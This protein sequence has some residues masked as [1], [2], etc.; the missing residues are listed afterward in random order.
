[1]NL[2]LFAKTRVWHSDYQSIILFIIIVGLCHKCTGTIRCNIQEADTFSFDKIWS[3]I[4]Q[5]WT[6][7]LSLLYYRQVLMINRWTQL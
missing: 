2:I 3:T 5:T 7:L 6:S 4:Q 1:M